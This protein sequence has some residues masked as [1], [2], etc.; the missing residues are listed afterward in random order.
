MLSIA[1]ITGANRGLGEELSN[2]ILERDDTVVI[3]ISRKITANQEEQ[4]KRGKFFYIPLDLS[5][6]INYDELKKVESIITS[7]SKIYFFN[8]AATVLPINNFKNIMSNEIDNSIKINVSNPV[9]LINYFL[10]NFQSNEINFVNITSSAANKSISHWSL[11]SSAKA[12]FNRFFEILTEEN[13]DNSKLNFFSIDPGIM[14]TGMQSEIRSAE[15][16]TQFIFNEAKKNGKL[17]TAKEVAQKL[18]S[19]L[20]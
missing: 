18:I 2:L 1:I 20:K 7:N 5:E 15:F 3:S 10:V 4:L 14:D 12:Y 11:Y 6:E 8:N 16:P 19:F 17:Q 9:L 13:K